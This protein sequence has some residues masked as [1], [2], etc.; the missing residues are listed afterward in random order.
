MSQTSPGAQGAGHGMSLVQV[1]PTHIW[2]AGH[3]APQLPQFVGLVRTSMQMSPQQPCPPPQAG[4][5]P[6]RQAP[7][8][9][10]SPVEHG[11]GH[12]GATQSPSTHIAPDAQR[13][14]QAPQLSVLSARFTHAAPQ[15]VSPVAHWG[16]LP[17][18]Q[19]PVAHM[20]PSGEQ[21]FPHAPHS[22]G[23]RAVFT[24]A[25]SQHSPVLHVPS[26]SQRGR[27]R[28]SRQI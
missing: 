22:K 24:H 3:I 16:P 27:Q 25:P 19:V 13:T 18:W 28:P 12:G 4:A 11:A 15:Q 14:P 6:Q 1:P 7:S 21:T 2:P 9:Q 23:S 26:G 8:M 20:L 17:H 10:V 5:M